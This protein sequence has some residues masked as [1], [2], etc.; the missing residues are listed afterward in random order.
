MTASRTGSQSAAAV[1]KRVRAQCRHQRT[2]GVLHAAVLID[3]ASRR[4]Q[5][6]HGTA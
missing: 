2:A 5:R 3:S 4:A 1:E 6:A